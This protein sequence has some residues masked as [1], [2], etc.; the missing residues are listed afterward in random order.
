MPVFGR[1]GPVGPYGPTGAT[2]PTGPVGFISIMEQ[3]NAGC[4]GTSNPTVSV[5]Q[6]TFTDIGDNG[7]TNG[8]H[9]YVTGTLPIGTYWI[10]Y[11]LDFF[12]LGGQCACAIQLKVD[13][14]VP[15]QTEGRAMCGNGVINTIHADVFVAFASATTHTLR[16]Q[17]RSYNTVDGGDILFPD[18]ERGNR[19]IRIIRIA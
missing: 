4:T 5:G 6:S 17:A 9:D 3:N 12:G 7:T 2:G 10:H 15:S 16:V 11:S 13:G 1:Q 8:W 19:T 14:S 18:Y